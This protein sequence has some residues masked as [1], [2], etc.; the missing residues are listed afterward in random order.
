MRTG[1]IR[2]SLVVAG[3]MLVALNTMSAASASSTATAEGCAAQF[4]EAQRVDMESFRDFDA[5]AF[6]AGHDPRSITVFAQGQIRY[7]LT[8]IQAA[9]AG[10]FVN[11]NAVWTWTEIYRVIDGCRSAFI[12]YDAT[13]AIP[14]IGFR[15]RAL[16]GVTYTHDGSRW[17]SIADQG[18]LLELDPPD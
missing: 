16:T 11:K 12:L 7:P 1:R 13:Y 10:H 18:T 5:D 8:A 17:L 9:L 14:S 3:A 4:E 2:Q 6:W 15:Q